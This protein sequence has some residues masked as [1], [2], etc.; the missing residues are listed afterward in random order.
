MDTPLEEQKKF[1]FT[2]CLLSLSIEEVVEKGCLSMDVID[3]VFLS[4]Y[5]YSFI[6]FLDWIAGDRNVLIEVERRL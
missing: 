3:Q 6:W 2:T 1:E 5:F 4:L